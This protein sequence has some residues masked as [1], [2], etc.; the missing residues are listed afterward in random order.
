VN[1]NLRAVPWWLTGGFAL[2][3]VASFVWTLLLHRSPP[4]LPLLIGSAVL[5][6]LLQRAT[7]FPG[8][9]WLA[10]TVNPAPVFTVDIDSGSR[11]VAGIDS[12]D[13]VHF[14]VVGDTG[15]QLWTIERRPQ[16]AS[17]I[18][19]QSLDSAEVDY[20]DLRSQVGTVSIEFPDG[21]GIYLTVRKRG[22]AHLAALIGEH[23]AP[24]TMTP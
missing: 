20:V 12:A 15:V 6:L 19:W 17:L 3:I 22:S 14:A 21:R 13:E 16:R 8:A 1:L 10:D 18:T 5:G 7:G 4:I 24:A 9:R 11:A 23:L 2:I